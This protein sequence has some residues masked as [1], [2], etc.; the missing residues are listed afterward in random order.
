MFWPPGAAM[1][2]AGG[3]RAAGIAGEEDPPEDIEAAAITEAGTMG[4][5]TAAADITGAT[6]MEVGIT[7]MA[8]GIT[9]TPPSMELPPES[10][11]VT[12]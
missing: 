7:D 5:V 9:G 2:A 3:P 12:G 6:T 11:R 4:A 10:L 8:A 1:G